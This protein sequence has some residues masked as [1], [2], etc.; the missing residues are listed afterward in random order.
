MEDVVRLNDT[1]VQNWDAYGLY[2]DVLRHHR[3]HL[4]LRLTEGPRL[5]VRTVA[6]RLPSAHSTLNMG[7]TDDSWSDPC[8]TECRSEL[9]LDLGKATPHALSLYRSAVTMLQLRK[10]V[11]DIHI[12]AVAGAPEER[13]ARRTRSQGKSTLGSY[14]R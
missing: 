10:A 13:S 11:H 5:D 6:S 1:D 3:C 8:D 12:V 9:K 2:D 4:S 7:W 14:A